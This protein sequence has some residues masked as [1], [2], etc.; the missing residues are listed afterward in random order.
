MLRKVLG[1][2]RQPGIGDVPLGEAR[3][4]QR[5]LVGDSV[6][7]GGAGTQRAQR[8]QPVGK[9]PA[10]VLEILRAGRDLVQGFRPALQ[11]LP[12]R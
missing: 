2:G 7:D 11:V 8:V 3:R 5:R 1:V 6:G 4:E 12:S 10:E 9:F